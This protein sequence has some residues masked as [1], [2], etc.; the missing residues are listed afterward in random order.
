MPKLELRIPPPVVLA[1][2]A[3]LMWLAAWALPS[4]RLMFPGRVLL[5]MAILISGMLIILAGLI[6]FRRARTTVNP[7]NPEAA[8]SLVVEGV[9][10]LTRNP[11]YLGMAVILIAWAVYLANPVSLIAVPCF[12]VYMNRF[13]IVPEEKVLELLFKSEFKSYMTRVR[14]WL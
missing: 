12:I 6:E 9:Y 5:A 7:L 14:R 13:Q 1:L 3:L 11:M 10:G 4:L 8:T 2:T